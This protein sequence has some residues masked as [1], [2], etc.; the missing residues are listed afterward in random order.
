MSAPAGPLQ[1]G[2]QPQLEV[3]LHRRV[4]LVAEL[5]VALHPAH[6]V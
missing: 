3:V 2:G 6:A 1:G 4:H 5:G